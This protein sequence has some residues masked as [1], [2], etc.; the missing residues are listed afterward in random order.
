MKWLCLYNEIQSF[1]GVH[2][3]FLTNMHSSGASCSSRDNRI[4]S[5]ATNLEGFCMSVELSHRLF[6][7]EWLHIKHGDVKGRSRSSQCVFGS[8]L[9]SSSLLARR[10]DSDR[11]KA[12]P[13]NEGAPMR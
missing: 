4:I 2:C 6:R 9:M 1:S 10:A 7:G 11:I 3:P 12:Q 8:C 5:P 13:V